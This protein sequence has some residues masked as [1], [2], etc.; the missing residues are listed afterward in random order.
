VEVPG[1]GV[2]ADPSTAGEPGAGCA[3]VV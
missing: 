2:A 3:K 1:R